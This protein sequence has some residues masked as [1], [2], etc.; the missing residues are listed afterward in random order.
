MQKNTLG[1][2]HRQ[3]VSIEL[4]AEVANNRHS[5]GFVVFG[6][7]FSPRNKWMALQYAKQ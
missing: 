4:N 6:N 7:R 2:I 5:Q 3:M 1:T